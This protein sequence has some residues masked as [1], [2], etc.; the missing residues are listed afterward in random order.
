MVSTPEETASVVSAP[1]VNT[2]EETASAVSAP[3]V[4]RA[5]L[6]W[7]RRAAP[8]QN[9]SCVWVLRMLRR[10]LAAGSVSLSEIRSTSNPFWMSLL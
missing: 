2:S 8:R 4:S 9:G 3:V 5:P 10:T 6:S 1:V 7:R